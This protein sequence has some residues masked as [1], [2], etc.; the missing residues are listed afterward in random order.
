MDLSL[1]SAILLWI[2]SQLIRKSRVEDISH[3]YT[4]KHLKTLAF[5]NFRF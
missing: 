4:F 5:L 3:G 1:L 2:V